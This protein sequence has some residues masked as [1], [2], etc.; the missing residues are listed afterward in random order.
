MSTTSI[1]TGNGIGVVHLVLGLDPEQEDH[2]LPVHLDDRPLQGHGHR[3]GRARPAPLTVK[4]T[5]C[6]EW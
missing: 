1:E 5:V 6:P 4:V 3:T 2:V